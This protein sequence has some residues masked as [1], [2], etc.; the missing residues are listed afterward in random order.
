MGDFQDKVAIVTGAGN[1]IGRAEALALAGLGAAVV[2][3]DLGGGS[4]D[5]VVSEIVAGGGRAVANCGDVSDWKATSDLVEQALSEF[6]RLDIV[7]ANAGIVRRSPIV[8]VTEKDLDDQLSI[9]FKGTFGLIRHAAAHWKSEH[10]AG[11]RAHRAVVA[12]S[13]SAGV[14]GG[15]QEFSVYGAM[16][17][18]IAALT[19]GAALE[20]RGFGVTVNAILPHAATRMDADAKGLP[21]PG[22][23]GSSDPSPDNPQHV[24]NVVCYLASERAAWLSGQV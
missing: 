18:G 17:S 6:G 1:G 4:A 2:V 21:D 11:N 13:S 19:L 3:N 23:F 5:A 24:A 10:S 7:V 15:V 20:F 9:L 16:K 8:E 14:P 12:T 22:V